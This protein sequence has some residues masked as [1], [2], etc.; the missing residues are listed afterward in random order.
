MVQNKNFLLT[1]KMELGWRLRKLWTVFWLCA[2][3][4]HTAVQMV[5]NTV[6]RGYHAKQIHVNGAFCSPQ[7]AQLH[8]AVLYYTNTP[9]RYLKSGHDVRHFFTVQDLSH[10]PCGTS[11]ILGL[12][13]F[14]DSNTP[15]SLWQP[16]THH[17]FTNC[18]CGN[19]SPHTPHSPDFIFEALILIPTMSILYSLNNPCLLL[20]QEPLQLTVSLLRG[21][22]G[23]LSANFPSLPSDPC[24]NVTS[25]KGSALLTL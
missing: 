11:S 8:V 4:P 24:H 12:H 5:H 22:L 1:C 7:P 16:K 21:I 19:K 6:L 13:L 3:M 25:S 15:Q 9:F 17:K 2:G 10:L 20:P 23:L 18:S 14:Y